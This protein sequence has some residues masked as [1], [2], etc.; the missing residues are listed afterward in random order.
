LEFGF[1][2][3]AM[4]KINKTGNVRTKVTPWRV[5]ATIVVVGK[6]TVCLFV[7]LGIQHSKCMHNSHLWPT[8]LYNNFPRY[9]INGAI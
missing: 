4:H 6:Q 7:A 1:G 9:L 2:L 3:P 5:R 8:Q